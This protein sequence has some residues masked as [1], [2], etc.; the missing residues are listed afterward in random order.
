MEECLL[1]VEPGKHA[2]DSHAFVE[3]VELLYKFG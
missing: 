1:L 3:L 2:K